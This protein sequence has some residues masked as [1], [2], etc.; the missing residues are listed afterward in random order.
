M[1]QARLGLSAAGCLTFLLSLAFGSAGVGKT[2]LT[3]FLCYG[4]VR[5]SPSWTIGCTVEVKVR[6]VESRAILV[7]LAHLPP[8]SLLPPFSASSPSSSPDP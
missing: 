4:E 1:G 2:S 6:G 8:P 7:S 3:H 5:G